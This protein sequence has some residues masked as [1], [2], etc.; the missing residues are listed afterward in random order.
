MTQKNESQ[1]RG[2]RSGT[3][4]HAESELTLTKCGKLDLQARDHRNC[5]PAQ[6]EAIRRSG[7]RDGAS[8]LF[9]TARFA[10]AI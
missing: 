2:S 7:L 8:A 1:R 3:N 5:A 9:F 10:A 6:E 4:R